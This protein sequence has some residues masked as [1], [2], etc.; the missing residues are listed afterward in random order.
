MPKHNKRITQNNFSKMID[1]IKTY[2]ENKKCQHRFP[3]K[4]S[5]TLNQQN[6]KTFNQFKK[7]KKQI[8]FETKTHSTS[9]SSKNAKTPYTHH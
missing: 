6:R 4:K 3:E 9:M 2:F 5:N 1:E 7:Q 8:T